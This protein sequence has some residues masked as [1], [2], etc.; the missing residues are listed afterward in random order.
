MD[1]SSMMLLHKIWLKCNGVVILSSMRPI[2]TL[3]AAQQQQQQQQY[4]QH[5]GGPQSPIPTFRRGNSTLAAVGFSTVEDPLRMFHRSERFLRLDLAH[6]DRDSTK[7]L[8]KDSFA[9]HGVQLDDEALEKVYNIT[10]G[11]L[12]YAYEVTRS[13]NEQNRG[14]MT[15]D[16]IGDAIAALRCNRIEEVI[17]HR[18]D[19]LN[20]ACQLLLK[21][22]SV[23][24]A[25]G[26]SFT[27]DLLLHVLGNSDD[28]IVQHSTQSSLGSEEGLSSALMEILRKDEFLTFAEHTAQRIAPRFNAAAAAAADAEGDGEHDSSAFMEASMDSM[29]TRDEGAASR[30]KSNVDLRSCSFEFGI[31]L[32]QLTIYGMLLDDQKEYLH[33]KV[34]SYYF[35][36]SVQPEAEISG[37]V[38]CEEG[39]HWQKACAWA[40][41]MSC[42]LRASEKLRAAG[43]IYIQRN[44]LL[45]AYSMFRSM[46]DDAGF[47]HE[48][49]L[50]L[51]Q[52]EALIAD[53]SS[54]T[55]SP[56]V[57]GGEHAAAMR[58]HRPRRFSSIEDDG[59]FAAERSASLLTI[60]SIYQ[61][62]GGDSDD[63]N[64]GLKVHIRLAQMNLLLYQD[65]EF[66]SKVLDDALQILLLSKNPYILNSK[67]FMRS[68]FN[69]AGGSGSGSEHKDEIHAVAGS[70]GARAGGLG[71]VAT[72]E[73]ADGAST[74]Q[75][76]GGGGGSGTA[77]GGPGT[78]ASN[79]KKSTGGKLFCLRNYSAFCFPIVSAYIQLNS[80]SPRCT[81]MQ[82]E[83]AL[84]VCEEALELA[85]REETDIFTIQL[86]CQEIMLRI[87][88][89][90]LLDAAASFRLLSKMYISS[91][92]HN[93]LIALFGMD[94]VVQTMGNIVP[95]LVLHGD[96][97]R[98][99]RIAD[100]QMQLIGKIKHNQSL[101][102][103]II[104]LCCALVQMG[105]RPKALEFC[106]KHSLLLSHLANETGVAAV[107]SFA[108]FEEWLT[109]LVKLDSD[110]SHHS[111]AS[112]LREDSREIDCILKMP[113]ALAVPDPGK[114]SAGIG[115]ES[116]GRG[117]I[118]PEPS[119]IS[120]DRDNLGS[121][122]SKSGGD[123]QLQQRDEWTVP[124]DDFL[125]LSGLTSNLLCA[126]M[127]LLKIQKMLLRLPPHDE[128]QILAQNREIDLYEASMEKFLQQSDSKVSQCAVTP[129]IYSFNLA[130]F[131]LRKHHIVSTIHA[132][133]GAAVADTREE[134]A[135]LEKMLANETEAGANGVDQGDVGTAAVAAAASAVAGV[136]SPRSAQVGMIGTVD[137][138]S[139]DYSIHAASNPYRAQDIASTERVWKLLQQ[140]A[141]LARDKKFVFALMV[142]GAGMQLLERGPP[143]ATVADKG[144]DGAG[145]EGGGEAAGALQKE[146]EE[147]GLQL[148]L[149]ADELLKQ[150]LS[151][152]YDRYMPKILRIVEYM[153]Q[154]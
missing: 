110:I 40:A 64:Y 35:N 60:E 88:E 132:R 47:M 30:M 27:F 149:K 62:F 78:N 103:A 22:A 111:D 72:A 34:A 118:G 6:L 9:S 100:Q 107:G 2:N 141:A 53:S 33:E 152:Q 148:Q 70:P 139:H 48:R 42:Y 61:I 80:W 125:L 92:H 123:N 13:I 52:L 12:L 18:F 50:N 99:V 113:D 109:R 115:R 93:K 127:C 106:T 8:I 31:R 124:I 119:E 26:S 114:D 56:F 143:A 142:V 3:V 122:S 134:D 67:H 59:S 1:A 130:F 58:Q 14:T 144:V 87:N 54:S 66:T 43:D 45:T 82:M 137:P 21:T 126:E 151:E 23:A 108:I 7:A 96:F 97:D 44:Y 51:H 37:P 49:S 112:P 117:S 85:A 39:F 20:A 83:K 91:R 38:L 98:A 146:S 102:A 73:W 81:A 16:Q 116:G 84:L 89:G 32:E 154:G 29:L 11:N 68:L 150:L 86:R 24:G 104:P 15:G 105:C 120:W 55:N 17:Y 145:V 140:T 10:G 76:G 101:A 138:T 46:C 135:R 36:F 25:N 65:Q 4:D 74:I 28:G 57:V 90:N 41:S 71:C 131:K 77:V 5:H 121:L 63:L 129:L 19:Q 128:E 69:H 95:Y 79:R 94:C 75:S 136:G 133:N 147:E 153:S